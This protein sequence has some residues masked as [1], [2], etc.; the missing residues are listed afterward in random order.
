VPGHGAIEKY[1]SAAN[2]YEKV[3]SGR[4]FLPGQS[5][6]SVFRQNTVCPKQ[7]GFEIQVMHNGLY[8]GNGTR[9]RE[10]GVVVGRT[11]HRTGNREDSAFGTDV[12]FQGQ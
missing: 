6:N 1:H 4:V 11:G 10:Y 12:E 7:G 8:S 5:V 2:G 3:P 9:R